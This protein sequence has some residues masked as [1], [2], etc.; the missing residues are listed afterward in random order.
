M[1]CCWN[2]NSN[3][4]DNNDDNDDHD[5]VDGDDRGNY[6][7]PEPAAE[8]ASYLTP[9][10]LE[11]ILEMSYEGVDSDELECAIC[12]E[13]FADGDSCRFLQG[14]GHFFHKLCV[15]EWLIKKPNCPIC[16]ATIVLG[17]EGID[18]MV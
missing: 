11:K 1:Y 8:E 3:D 14:C 7:E 16:R 5:D 9:E 18:W 4:D 17:D 13:P 10:A 6:T 12:F 15:D 2:N